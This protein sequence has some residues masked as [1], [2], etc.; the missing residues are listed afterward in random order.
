MS[1][2]LEARMRAWA[3]RT[4]AAIA[5]GSIECPGDGSLCKAHIEHFDRHLHDCPLEAATRELH[6]IERELEGIDTD[7]FCCGFHA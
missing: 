5:A 4:R 6:R 3:G 2:E 1:P 7:R